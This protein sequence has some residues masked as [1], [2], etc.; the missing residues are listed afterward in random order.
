MFRRQADGKAAALAQGAFHVDL[1]LHDVDD[2]LDERQ[3]QP[4]ARC[5]MRGIALIKL[6]KDVCSG[7]RIH[8]AAG[9]GDRDDDLF[10][11]AKGPHPDAAVCLRKFERVG[12][13]I[14]P[15][16]RQQLTVGRDRQPLFD[17]GLQIDLP[18]LPDLFKAQQAL[19]QLFPEIVRLSLQIDVLVFQLVETQDVG[20][21][22]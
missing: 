7:L 11:L 18:V 3:P 5:G 12:E 6:F 19:G 10:V 2:P 15:D 9:I 17:I 20:D 14:V 22:L 21:E 13:Q 4:V 8:P 1:R 16:E